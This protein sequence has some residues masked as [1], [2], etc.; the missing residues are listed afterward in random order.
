MFLYFLIFLNICMLFYGF[1]HILD[2]K[3]ILVNLA[4]SI[5]VFLCLYMVTSGVMWIL[6]MFTA[7]FCMLAVT[8]II[9]VF[10]VIVYIKS[11]VKGKEF[12]VLSGV[13]YDHRTLINRAAIILA[14]VLSVGAYSTMGIGHNDGNAQI[15]ALS[16]LNENNKRTFAVEE[17]DNIASK[18]IYETFFYKTVSEIDKEKFTAKYTIEKDP[19]G[20]E[21]NLM[22]G[23]YGCNP[24]YPSVLALGAKIFG[25][26]RMAFIQ[27]LFAFCLFVFTD[28]ILLALKCDW[29]LRSI[30]VSL[31]GLSPVII[32]SN[33]TTLVEPVIGFC[34]VMFLYM[35]VCKDEKRQLLSILAVFA[36]S[37]LNAV[38]YI[39]IPLIFV[40]YALYYAHTRKKI[41]LVS[42]G[43]SLIGYV[44]GFVY[45]SMIA[46]ENTMIN[47]QIGI[48]FFGDKVFIF[49][50]ILSIVAFVS[51]SIL[52]VSLNDVKEE[53]IRRFETGIGKKIFKILVTVSA[54]A[55]LIL[56]IVQGIM[57]CHSFK[58]VTRL[59]LSAFTICSGVSVIP[60]ILV[61]LLSTKY[62]PDE[63]E[64]AVIVTFIYTIMLYSAVMKVSIERYYYDARFLASFL[65]FAI[66]AG[67]LALNYLKNEMKYYLPL[68]GMFILLVPYSATLIANDCE[69]RM[70]SEVFFDVIDYV[71]ENADENTVVFVEKN[72]M[73]YFYYPLCELT[74]VRIYPM[75]ADLIED[76]VRDTGDNSSNVLYITNKDEISKY[77][78]TVEYYKKFYSRRFSE[79][80]LS[81]ALGLPNSLKTRLA[82]TVE[83]LKVEKL[84]DLLSRFSYS[85]MDDSDFNL[86]VENVEVDENNIAHVTLSVTDSDEILY[87]DVY[88]LSYHLDYELS[89]DLYD[90][91]RVL[92]GPFTVEK[93]TY[94]FSLSGMNEDL[95]VMFDV[96]EEGVAWYSWD[97][98]VPVVSFSKDDEGNWTYKTG[99]QR[100]ERQ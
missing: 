27:A 13:Q 43:V 72:L 30:L 23:D 53:D 34:L 3:K 54:A 92:I 21:K 51:G 58:E 95:T 61:R 98:D 46:Y 81:M 18:S 22:I 65:P 82:G 38:V 24:V 11:P 59:T 36:L 74:D 73:K 20:E 76:F 80:D 48:P 100:G 57:N 12:F 31:L 63:K 33:H 28:E 1:R 29:K 42:A 90:L 84:S 64:A 94:D 79:T 9:A 10:F 70:D 56:V 89:E 39:L 93:Y 71:E 8:F 19:S 2:S 35:L 25:I 15:R 47:Y 67:G 78:H 60:V 26:R 17:F 83:I 16:I 97:N 96:L 5:S 41:Y 85:K 37:V 66:I 45:M 75:T 99:T 77:K 52:L 6:E 40:L 44:L 86:K 62:D 7:E 55:F 68:V 50:I 87:N 88:L 4:E 91:P 32:Y 49:V 14:T 69:K